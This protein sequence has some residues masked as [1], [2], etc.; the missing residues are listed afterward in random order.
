MLKLTSLIAFAAAVT[1]SLSVS[2]AA[3]DPVITVQIAANRV[4]AT[5]V[6][7]RGEVIFFGR[8]VIYQSGMPRLDRHAVVL[9]DDD[10]DGVVTL[11]LE[12]NVPKYS[13][14]AVVDFESGV[15]VIASPA[16][17]TPPRVDLPDVVWRGGKSHIDL[18]R[19]YVD[20]LF[21]RPKHGAWMLGMW[22]GGRF[23]ADTKN[24]AKLRAGLSGM[25]PLIGTK[26]APPTATPRDVI[27]II[28]PRQLDVF[29]RQAD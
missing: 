3:T 26:E 19:D 29:M 7:P 11:T 1:L 2:L 25:K 12:Q 5:G 23:D 17:F 18:D 28:D 22:Q 4:T 10:R 8:S 9:T 21:V 14:W 16:G 15:S 20:V 24:D 6:T 13:T 27:V